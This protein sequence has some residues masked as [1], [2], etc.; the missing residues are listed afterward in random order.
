MSG[1]NASI[2]LGRTSADLLMPMHMVVGQTGHIVSVGS[3]LA[4]LRPSTQLVGKRFLEV[5]EMRRPR[6]ELKDFPDLCSVA[7]LKIHLQFRDAPQ[8][9]LKGMMA[10]LRDGGGLLI[11]LSFGISLVDAVRQYGLSNSD[12]AAT[13]LAIELLYLFEAKTAVMNEM[14][15]LN[16]RLQ[17]A[18]QAAEAQASTD[19]LTGLNNRR[20]MDDLL[21]DLVKNR[22]SF[23]LMHLDLDYFKSV[24]DTFGHAAGDFV[25]QEASNIL[26]QEVRENDTVARVGGDEFV[27]IFDRLTNEKKLLKIA[28]RIVTRLEEPVCFQDQICRISGSIGIT[29]SKKY[30]KL[31]ADRMQSDADGALYESKRRGRACATMA[32]P[33]VTGGAGN[34]T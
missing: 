34:P 17:T 13:D 16:A 26:R 8:T 12:F 9:P 15:G 6:R 3:T 27:L 28:G 25:L 2:V 19:A 20:A 31:D 18:R 22:A 14:H 4:R 21:S 10:E 29:T 5:F 1:S 33:A 30:G 11:N 32:V 23:G 7:G 24:N